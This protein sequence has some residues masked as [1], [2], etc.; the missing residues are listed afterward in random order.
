MLD[1]LKR[2]GHAGKLIICTIVIGLLIIGIANVITAVNTINKEANSFIYYLEHKELS[3]KDLKEQTIELANRIFDFAGDRIINTPIYY[4]P[5]FN[6]SYLNTSL[7]QSEW[8]KDTKNLINYSYDS[9]ITYNKRFLSEVI[10]IKQEFQ[11]RNLTDQQLDQFYDKPTNPIGMQIVAGR[12]L[13]L[14]NRLL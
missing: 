14:A 4:N 13:E 10:R 2:R 3:D 9:Q 6:Q 7:G 12:L 1:W 11:K 8:D 5:H